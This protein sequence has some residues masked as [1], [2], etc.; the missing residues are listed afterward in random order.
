MADISWESTTTGYVKYVT[1]ERYEKFSADVK[2]W[3]KPYRCSHCGEDGVS[4]T[5]WEIEELIRY[6]ECGEDFPSYSTD[7]RAL[8]KSLTAKLYV[9]RAALD[10]DK[11]SGG[12]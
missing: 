4:L 2:R 5:A 1:N 10:Q 12:K 6:S 11:G 7:E 8:W 9:A 3:Y